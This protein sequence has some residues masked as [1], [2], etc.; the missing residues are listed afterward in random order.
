MTECILSFSSEYFV[1]SKKRKVKNIQNYT[2][3]YCFVNMLNFTSHLIERTE[4]KGI[5]SDKRKVKKVN[6]SQ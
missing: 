2:F 6:V 1:L 4:I 5:A 3:T